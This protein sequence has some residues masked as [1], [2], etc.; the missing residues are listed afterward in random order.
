MGMKKILPII[1]LSFF[2]ASCIAIE[3]GTLKVTY[4]KCD[5]TVEDSSIGNVNHYTNA[6]INHINHLY[7]GNHTI[8]YN[9]CDIQKVEFIPNAK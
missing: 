7:V 9:V 8:A 5:G 2:L 1:L 3:Y 4:K 6:Y